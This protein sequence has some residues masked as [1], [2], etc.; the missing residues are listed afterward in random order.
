MTHPHF[1][2]EIQNGSVDPA[3]DME[4][5]AGVEWFSV[6]HWVS[7]EQDGVSATVLPLDAP[8][9]RLGDINSPVVP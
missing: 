8:L 6:Q 3:R 5:G 7:V 2:Y 1:R 9:V 4:P